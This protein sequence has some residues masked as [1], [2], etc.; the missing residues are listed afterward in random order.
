MSRIGDERR[1]QRYQTRTPCEIRFVENSKL[2]GGPA[3]F[4]DISILGVL[5]ECDFHVPVDTVIAIYLNSD[6][7][8]YAQVV[9][10]TTSS[11]GNHAIGAKF[12]E[13]GIPYGIFTNIAFAPEHV[14]LET[15]GLEVVCTLR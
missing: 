2:V 3:T 5:V 1:S 14:C 9:R 8:I 15:K 10:D 12:I 11:D 13:G 4:V 7:P 6:N